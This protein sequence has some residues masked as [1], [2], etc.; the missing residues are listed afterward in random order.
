[1]DALGECRLLQKITESGFKALEL[2][3]NP[4]LLSRMEQNRTIDVSPGSINFTPPG[5][6]HGDPVISS[7]Y[8]VN[9]NLPGLEEV[10]REI[11]RSISAHFFNDLFMSI[12]EPT[13]QMTAREVMERNSE[14]MQQLGPVL[15]RLRS[16]MFQPLIERVFGLLFRWHQIPNPPEILEGMELKIEFISILAQAQ[17][18]AG[19]ASIESVVGFVGSV[20]QMSPD[21]LDKLN[22]DEAIEQVAEMQGVPPMVLRSDEE[23]AEL[24]GQRQ[25]K[26][27][28]AEQMAMMEKGA[29][30][31]AQGGKTLQGL[32]QATKGA[33]VNPQQGG[34]PQ[35][36]GGAPQQ[37]GNPQLQQA[38]QGILGGQNGG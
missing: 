36:Q 33:Q 30:I 27:A 20:A 23:V 5:L 1:M 4:P 35:Q 3:I 2:Q 31:A 15:D 26:M 25:Q 32:T 8:Q 14:K 13:K 24:R 6:S 11:R 7:L 22:I 12:T 16:E 19:I 17:K 28:Q 18:H 10:K 37:G 29:G 38:L 21:A 34:N 9:P